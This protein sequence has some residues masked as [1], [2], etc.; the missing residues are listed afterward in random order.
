MQS[1]SNG[2]RVVFP[3]PG[4]GSY[5]VNGLRFWGD[6]CIACDCVQ[7]PHALAR[8]PSCHF[9]FCNVTCERRGECPEHSRDYEEGEDYEKDDDEAARDIGC[10]CACCQSRLPPFC[11]DCSVRPCICAQV[12]GPGKR[13]IRPDRESYNGSDGPAGPTRYA[14]DKLWNVRYASWLARRGLDPLSV[15]DPCYIG[16]CTAACR[17][18]LVTA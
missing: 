11:Y 12:V 7:E 6:T 18:S 10:R 2:S 5:Y 9:L 14:G 15:A 8:C 4:Q 16:Y 3:E 17:V 13:W 1:G